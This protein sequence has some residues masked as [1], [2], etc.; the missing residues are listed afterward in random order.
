MLPDKGK[1]S[2]KILNV[3]IISKSHFNYTFDFYLFVIFGGLLFFIFPNVIYFHLPALTW[4]IYIELNNFVCPLTYLENWLLYQ[5][6]LST[7]SNTFISN[8]ILPTVYPENL[9]SNLQTYLG[10]LLIIIN[11]Y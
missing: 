3:R 5:S 4:G 2:V 7:Y 11:N 8:Y 10:V 1:I 9:T 6:G